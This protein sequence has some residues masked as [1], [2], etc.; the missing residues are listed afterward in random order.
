VRALPPRRLVHGFN[1]FVA[2]SFT[3]M[4]DPV[5]SVTYAIE[6]A[7]R[8]LSGDA[9]EL[10][11][12]MALVIAAVAVVAATYDQLIRRY[13]DGGGAARSLG[14]AFGEGWA[15]LPLGALLVD[16]TLTIAVSCSASASAAIAYVPELASWRVP[17]AVGLVVAVAVVCAAGHRGRVAFATATLAFGCLALLVLG[18][19]F[20]G[21]DPDGGPAAVSPPL[22]G[23][24]AL[25]AALLAMPLGMALA[26]GIEAPTSAI[27]QLG[28][29]G[30]RGRELF[31]RLT[32]WLL[33]GIL[34][35]LTLGFA[36]LAVRLGVG[37]PGEE[38]TLMAEIARVATGGGAEFAAFQ[39][40]SMLLLLA[41]AAS[42]YL[43]G[44]GLLKALAGI[45]RDGRGLLPR[46]FARV[47][48]AYAPPWGLAGLCA[49]A[50]VL[51]IAAAGREQTLVQ[52]YAVAV[53][54]SF[55]GATVAA[56]TLA[57]RERRRLSAAVAVAGALIVAAVLVLNLRRLDGAIALAAALAVSIY[58]WRSW[59]RRGRPAG[60]LRAHTG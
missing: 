31:G 43:A 46:R 21:A 25:G 18:R 59:A 54:A 5:S 45:G 56:A 55:L 42:S 12:T 48:R 24:A 47:N 57:R 27:A 44:S 29:L 9:E 40:A 53:F 49:T 13:P 2:F 16:F 7:L 41:A 28:Q 1:L 8:A 32:I 33:V 37:L 19:G 58:L 51:V 23:D 39:V 34:A 35:V 52:F 26:T 17:L 10:V 22:V 11:L 3:V 60:A 6:A 15:F 30:D 20:L 4:A 50:S 36:A 38:T 14:E